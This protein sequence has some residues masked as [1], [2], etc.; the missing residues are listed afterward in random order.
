VNKGKHKI[1][2]PYCSP[3]VSTKNVK[4]TPKRG[5]GNQIHS[6]EKKGNATDGP[7]KSNL[8]ICR[9]LLNKTTAL[10]GRGGKIKGEKFEVKWTEGRPWPKSDQ[11][12]E[13]RKR[14]NEG[15]ESNAEKKL[16]GGMDQEKGE[17]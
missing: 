17:C 9:S 11:K 7:K 1:K 10:A 15:R 3:E 4:K 6:R 13:K 2:K 16:K 12:R 8:G 5:M 14:K